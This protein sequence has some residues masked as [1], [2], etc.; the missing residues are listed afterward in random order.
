[1][2]KTIL[3][4]RLTRDPEIRYTQ[5]GTAIARFTLAVNRMKKDEAD[6]ISC[7]AFGKTAEIM[8]KYIK[9]GTEIM[10]CGRIETGSYEKDGKKVFTTDV[11][12]DEIDFVGKKEE[13]PA[14][15]KDDFVPVE[16]DEE[17][18]FDFGGDLPF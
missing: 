8:E 14:E 6:F 15:K 16:E 18:P 17:L 12:A 9:K 5:T 2:N 4:G 7:K 13:K 10:L 11:I 1:M 3:H